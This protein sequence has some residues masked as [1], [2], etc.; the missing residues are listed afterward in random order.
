MAALSIRLRVSEH[1]SHTSTMAMLLAKSS[2]KA[3]RV[4]K[5]G[6]SLSSHIS[7]N[8]TTHRRLQSPP[9]LSKILTSQVRDEWA[10]S[11]RDEQGT[12]GLLALSSTRR[13]DPTCP[14]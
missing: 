10:I 2:V 14:S 3:V 1:I 6:S 4:R 12:D 13:N 8:A 11:R 5:D 7:L 9:R